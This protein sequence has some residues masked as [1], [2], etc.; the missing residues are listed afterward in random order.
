MLGQYRC[1]ETQ[2]GSDMYQDIRSFVSRFCGV[3]LIKAIT[4]VIGAALSYLINA[5]NIAFLLFEISFAVIAQEYEVGGI[6][7]SI[8]YKEQD[9]NIAV[10]IKVAEEHILQFA[11]RKY[12][13]GSWKTSIGLCDVEI[14][15]VF[16]KVK[17]VC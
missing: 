1:A 15:L 8:G 12:G 7:T 13:F 5:L 3:K 2:I 17:E 14:D 6:R 16:G 4:I 10:F 11:I 9:I